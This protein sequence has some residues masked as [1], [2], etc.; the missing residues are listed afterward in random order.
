M[1]RSICGVD[2]S[3]CSLQETCGGCVSTNGRPFQGGCVVAQCCQQQ[4]QSYCSGC[5]YPSCQLKEELLAAFRGSGI[6]E[7][8]GLADLNAVKGSFINLAYTLPNGETVKL[9][10]DEKIYLGNQV[11]QKVPGRYYG[12]AAD[13]R[14]LL[15]CEYGEHGDDAAVVFYKKRG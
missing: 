2:C 8:T 3:S 7:L 6:P 15:I 11:P 13:E 5:P 1:T 12:L 10:D 9:L 4:G 14:G